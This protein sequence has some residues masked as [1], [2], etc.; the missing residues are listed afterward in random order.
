VSPIPAHSSEPIPIDDLTVP[1]ISPP[2][3]VIPRWSGQSTWLGE[4]LIG[5]DR[6][7]HVGR[8]DRHLIVA[9]AV[10]LEDPDMVE[11]AFD[12]RLGARLAIFLEQVLLQAPGIDPDPDRAAIGAGRRDDFLTRSCDPILPGLIRRQAAP[13]SAASSARL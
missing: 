1:P 13:A 6:E 12:Q 10:V 4:L 2:A 5:G 9:K 11:R 3:S 8:L 7:E